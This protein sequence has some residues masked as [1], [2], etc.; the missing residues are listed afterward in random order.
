VLFSCL[1]AGD[2][3][4]GIGAGEIKRE[5]IVK[6]EKKNARVIWSPFHDITRKRV[7]ET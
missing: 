7:V 6:K 5:K 1:N 2:K 4:R 3:G